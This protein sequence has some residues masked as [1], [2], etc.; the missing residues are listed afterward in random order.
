M[1]RSNGMKSEIQTKY[2]LNLEE[3]RFS[4]RVLWAYCLSHIFS[5]INSGML[6]TKKGRIIPN[7]PSV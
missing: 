5:C 3:D 2:L 1:R 7:F 6:E 4:Y